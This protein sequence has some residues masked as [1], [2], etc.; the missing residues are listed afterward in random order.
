MNTS[1]IT[2]LNEI[3]D[4]SKTI[5]EGKLAYFRERLRLKLYDVIMAA[6][7]DLEKEGAL[8]RADLARR[9]NKDPA[10]ITKFFASPGNWTVDTISDLALGVGGCELDLGLKRLCDMPARNSTHLDLITTHK[11]ASHHGR[12]LEALNEGVKQEYAMEYIIKS[13][14]DHQGADCVR[15]AK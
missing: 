8:T 7:D 13:T 6:F 11:K 14:T 9:I 15:T 10:Q 12:K 2:F 5:P 4:L 1:R 3:N